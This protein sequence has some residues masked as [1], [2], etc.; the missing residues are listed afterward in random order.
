MH[1]L[2][3]TISKSGLIT[4][5]IQGNFTGSSK[6]PE[7]VV[8]RGGHIL[9]LL[10]L[11]EAMRLQT[12]VST[13]AFGCLRSVQ[14]FRLPGS[15]RDYI[16]VGSDS[17]RITILEYDGARNQFAKVHMETFGRSG[18][19][20]IV[21]GEYL[22]ADPRGRAVMIGAIEKQKLVYVL[23]RDT[24]SKLTIS[25]PLEAHKGNTV[26]FDL[27]GVDVG[28]DNP[29]FAALEFDY[30]DVHSTEPG[31]EQPQKVLTYYELDLGLNHVSRR[32]SEPVDNSANA[33]VPCP[34]WKD[35]PGGVLVCS[36]GWVSWR[37]EGKTPVGVPLPR[38]SGREDEEIL[39]LTTALHKTRGGF[40]AML[41]SELGDLYRVSLEWH[42]DTVTGIEVA[43]LDT[44][45]IAATMAV[46][47]NGYLF[48]APEAGPQHLYRILGLG[49]P[50]T[51]TSPQGIPTFEPSVSNLKNLEP[52][53]ELMSL[54]PMTDARVRIAETEA[55]ARIYALCGRGEGASALRILRHGLVAS[56]V[57][58]TDLKK[59]P[60]GVWTVP[61]FA[62]RDGSDR[63]IVLSFSATTAVLSVSGERMGEV[64]DSGLSTTVRTIA[65]GVLGSDDGSGDISAIVQVHPNGIRIVRAGGRAQ[66]WQ[67]GD[68]RQVR[69][70]AINGVQVAVVLNDNELLYFELDSTGQ[71]SLTDKLPSDGA[72]IVAVALA[73][74]SARGKGRFLAFADALS[75]VHIHSL[76]P[77]DNL[78]PTAVQVL[79]DC[80]QSL[81]FEDTAEG[82]APL[83][84]CV[85]LRNGMLMRSAV[86]SISGTLSDTR[87]RLLGT[88]PVRLQQVRAA[89]RPALLALSSRPWLCCAGGIKSGKAAT[90]SGAYYMVPIAYVPLVAAAPFAAGQ[91]QNGFVAI[92]ESS[93][94][95][96]F[97]DKLEDMFAYTNVPMPRTPR[98][99]IVYPASNLMISIESDHIVST[100]AWS[101]AIRVMASDDAKTLDVAELDP[102]ESA[103]SLCTCVFRDYDK[104]R[105]FVVV[106]TASKLV[107]APKRSCDGGFISVY[108]I[109]QQQKLALVHKTRVDDA[110][111]ALAAFQGRLLAGIGNT[112]RLYDMGKKQ[113]LRKCER[114]DIGNIICQ[115][116]AMGERIVVGD[117][118]ES[119]SFAKYNREENRIALF[120]DDIAPRW[121][122][123]GTFLDYDTI[124]GSD[125]FG[126]IF[127]SRLPNEITSDAD[128]DPTGALLAEKSFLNGAPYRTECVACFHVGDT[129]TSLQKAKFTHG[130]P[131]V[132][133]YT[134][135]TGAVGALVPL[136]S[137]E[138][139]NF[140]QTLEMHMR[141]ENPPLCGRDHLA[142]RS[143]YFPVKSVI[144]GDLCEQFGSLP[145]EVQ[146]DIAQELERKPYE[147]IE[148]MADIRHTK[149][150]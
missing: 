49:A 47:R 138:D 24:Q 58:A 127:I 79:D 23:S 37:S 35:G 146:Q 145:H 77:G 103:V 133:V 96:F 82:P 66:E 4:K 150:I 115:I 65:A 76:A 52:A 104:E 132:L 106:G 64:Q 17:G 143:A 105:V 108:S 142:Y 40:F 84:L 85:G 121:L 139:V 118:S 75:R 33:L 87:I 15:T 27:C 130:S 102:T 50:P 94:R 53:D 56:Q 117:V 57:G 129:V 1:L 54:C 93:M 9:E 147:V 136:D 30:S 109:T 44:T 6:L 135:I 86:D 46:L 22:A 61:T 92:T 21:P 25:S 97:L 68:H 72:E 32:W 63:Y 111:L 88:T 45:P 20:R 69:H 95:V 123:A 99:L 71:L 39:V 100:G 26:L 5:C 122:A 51:T 125:K 14:P 8:I 140:F 11:D 119:F 131:E 112:L 148:K 42:G 83:H 36:A 141:A 144:D 73:P 55:A 60:T 110:P 18:C 149:L 70:A 43:Y 81:A 28:F 90:S 67:P 137:R 107:L 120:A 62:S 113:L 2:S 114:K 3:L 59:E 7:L 126:N 13:D 74:A 89:G 48:L 98:K 80:A 10:K 31:A 29:I 12:L 124:A 128:E 34:G 41:Q 78:M 91:G 19:R 101:S 134:T 116:H 16:V 38:R